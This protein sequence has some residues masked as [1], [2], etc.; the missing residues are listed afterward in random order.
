MA[1]KILAL[2]FWLLMLCSLVGK[3]ERD[4]KFAHKINNK[5]NNN[6]HDMTSR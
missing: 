5:N 4:A 6:M 2:L 1:A 3:E